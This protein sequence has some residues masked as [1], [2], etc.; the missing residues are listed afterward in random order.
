[1][2]Q[3]LGSICSYYYPN[4]LAQ[5]DLFGCLAE[6]LVLEA[7]CIVY[8]LLCGHGAS[9]LICDIRSSATEDHGHFCAFPTSQAC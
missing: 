2:W 7:L 9:Q 8:N 3:D 4:Q 1:M 6:P 5:R